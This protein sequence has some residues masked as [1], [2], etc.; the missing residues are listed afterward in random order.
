VLEVAL[1]GGCQNG[2]RTAGACHFPQ[3]GK[4]FFKQLTAERLVTRIVKGFPRAS[5][6]KEPGR[7]NE[8]LE[9][10]PIA[11]NRGL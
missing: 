7:R 2:R 6:E 8:A 5:W 11:W 9:H 10:I 1:V 4:E 3:Y